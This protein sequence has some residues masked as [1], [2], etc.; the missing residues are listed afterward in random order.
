M[1]IE[2]EQASHMSAN[3]KQHVFLTR[4]TCLYLVWLTAYLTIVASHS[5]FVRHGL[6]KNHNIMPV[7][8]MFW[9]QTWLNAIIYLCIF[10]FPGLVLCSW[11]SDQEKS[12]WIFFTHDEDEVSRNWQ[13]I[14]FWFLHK[15]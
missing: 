4:Q 9:F 15:T 13:L 6:T 11:A 2:G 12:I 10:Y 8:R 1:F 14:M 3:S 5:L 7:L